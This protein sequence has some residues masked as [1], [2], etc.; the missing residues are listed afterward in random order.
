MCSQALDILLKRV[1]AD[2]LLLTVADT[3][4]EN[5]NHQ[6]QRVSTSDNTGSVGNA[7]MKARVQHMLGK[8]CAPPSSSQSSSP[9][10]DAA[11][12]CDQLKR[13]LGLLSSL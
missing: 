8:A 12:V 10:G 7:D 4:G 2:A 3:L 11:S 13:A 6:K 5:K 9:S 1:L